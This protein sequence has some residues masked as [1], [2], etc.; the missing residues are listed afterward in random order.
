MKIIQL[1]NYTEGF[2]TINFDRVDMTSVMKQGDIS[3]L[4]GK[5]FTWRRDVGS[6]IGDCPFFVGAMPIFATEKLGSIIDSTVRTATFTVEGKSYTIIAA[7]L[8]KGEVINRQESKCRTF[9]SG[10]I[11][12]VDKFIFNKGIDYPVLFVPEEYIMYTFCDMEFAKKLISCHFEQL[13][14]IECAIV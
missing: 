12:S 11:M 4:D 9:R 1:K 13:Q 14:L 2:A 3:V 6:N 5:E 8:L 7:P 10:K